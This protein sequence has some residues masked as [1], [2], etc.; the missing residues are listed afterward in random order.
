M[1]IRN[2]SPDTIA[3]GGA[4]VAGCLIVSAAGIVAIREAGWSLIIEVSWVLLVLI[5]FAI[6]YDYIMI[7]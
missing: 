7:R 3:K 5:V 2:A 6:I 4:I 1:A